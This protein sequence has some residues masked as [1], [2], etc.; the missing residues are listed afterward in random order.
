VAET[1]IIKQLQQAALIDEIRAHPL[2]FSLYTQLLLMAAGPRHLFVRWDGVTRALLRHQIHCSLRAFA[3]R[4]GA[5]RETV[6]RHLEFLESFGLIEVDA[7]SRDGTIITLWGLNEAHDPPEWG[8]GAPGH[9]ANDTVNHKPIDP[10]KHAANPVNTAGRN[11]PLG[12]PLSNVEEKNIIIAGAKATREQIRDCWEVYSASL[13]KLGI[14]PKR[15][16]PANEMSLARAINYSGYDDV[17]DALEGV[18]YEERSGDF[19]PKK[20]ISLDYCLHRNSKTGRMNLER[21]GNIARM[22]RKAEEDQ[23]GAYS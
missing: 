16:S 1:D 20:H 8:A 23:N 4:V 2:R 9:A 5:D 17:R 7:H 21:L 10:A 22:K 18:R 6:A 11:P 12:I 13:T 14:P 19:D 3:Q 15:I